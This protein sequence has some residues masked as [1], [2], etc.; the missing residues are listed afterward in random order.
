MI[1]DSPHTFMVTFPFVT[2]LILKP[3]VGIISSEKFP[4]YKEIYN[5]N[6]IITRHAG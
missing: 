4:L 5:K 3:T 1:Y 6:D 2:F